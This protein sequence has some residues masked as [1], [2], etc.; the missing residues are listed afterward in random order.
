MALIPESVIA[1]VIQ[2]SNIVEVINS[3]VPLKKAGNGSWKACCPFHQEKTPSFHVSET[4][5]LFY[6]FGCQKGGDVVKFMREYLNLDYVETIRQLAQRCGVHIPENVS[7][8]E[9]QAYRRKRSEAGRLYDLHEALATF[10]RQELLNNPNSPVAE[11]FASR[12]IPAEYAEKFRIG[13]AP[14][15]WDASISFLKKSGFTEQEIVSAGV[16]IEKSPGGR[17]YDRFRNRL[18]FSITD[19][20]NRVIGFSAR[21]I[22]KD[23][24]SPK[25][26]NSPETPIFHKGSILYGLAQARDSIRRNKFA[27]VCEG[28][29]DT[30]A[31]HRAGLDMAVAP[32]GLAF[33]SEQAEL[34]K[35]YT[36]KL[37]LCFDSDAAGQQGT[38][39]VLEFLLPMNFEI[40][41]FNIAGGKDPDEIMRTQGA[42]ILHEAL[43]NALP[44]TRIILTGL[45]KSFDL[46]TPNGKVSA[47]EQAVK[48][49][50]TVP[51][52]MLREAYFEEIASTLRLPINRLF[53]FH[54]KQRNFSANNY[55]AVQGQ[56]PQSASQIPEQY[57][58]M[59]PENIRHA[60]A[61]L[62]LLA[63]HSAD[64]PRLIAE[65]LDE[66][67]LSD[68]PT[69]RVLKEL[70]NM[71]LNGEWFTGS[72]LLNHLPDDLAQMADVVKML[73]ADDS[74][75]T[76]AQARQILQDCPAELRKTYLQ[77]KRQELLY[78]LRETKDVVKQ[79]TI[80]EE[81]KKLRD[82]P[83]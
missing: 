53:E 73:M 46:T 34:L 11:Y 5:Q 2:R 55:A 66:S 78:E 54:R 14:D 50:G 23:D 41:S 36:D 37:Y 8:E 27:I 75:L 47:A 15:S 13:A 35:R 10:Y 70:M 20:N 38:L 12:S 56:N 51:N 74:S 4:K 58:D 68:S 44:L 76:D 77:R 80:L 52:P 72:E 26:V 31:L 62:L 57:N 42:E 19:E 16:A 21:I 83:I 49:L 65:K 60:E 39:R 9:E 63:L 3:Y 61:S 59:R 22:V 69:A 32:Q 29:L 18:V 25:Y 48:L 43:K 82:N 40:Y 33:R 24:N 64:G 1:E 28:Q 67:L 7:P 30:I 6:C 81:L 17:I 79:I 45:Q 71:A